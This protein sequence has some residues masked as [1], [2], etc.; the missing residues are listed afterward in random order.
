MSNNNNNNKNKKNRRRK[1][2]NAPTLNEPAK[3]VIKNNKKERVE[4]PNVEELLV[5][6]ING[7]KMVVSQTGIPGYVYSSFGDVNH[8]NVK[9]SAFR[10]SIRES[11]GKV[12]GTKLV[13][14]FGGGKR[15]RK[16]LENKQTTAV[17]DA[18]KE[19]GL[20]TKKYI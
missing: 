1:A 6:F 18:I 19:S 20:S 3:K 11:D 16:W 10:L 4:K 12:N 13:A 17:I 5:H 14:K 9:G 15:F 8:N 2:N 7:D